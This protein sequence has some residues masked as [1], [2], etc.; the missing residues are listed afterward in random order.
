M[1]A[2]KTDAISTAA[3]SGQT[4]SGAAQ[5]KCKHQPVMGA[6][7]PFGIL[8]EVAHHAL[9]LTPIPVSAWTNVASV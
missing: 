4:G 5:H 7:Q 2:T 9:L 3:L 6:N 8:I 1:L